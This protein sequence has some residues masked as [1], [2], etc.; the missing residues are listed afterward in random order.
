[1]RRIADLRGSSDAEFAALRTAMSLH[2]EVG[3]E[4]A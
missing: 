2:W 1:M 4:L 3:E